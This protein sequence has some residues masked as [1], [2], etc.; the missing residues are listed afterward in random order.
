MRRHLSSL[1]A[2]WLLCQLA[3][4]VAAPIV[5]GTP[6]LSAAAIVEEC[7]CPGSV[8]GQACPMHKHGAGEKP[9]QPPA[10]DCRLQSACDPASAAL[11]S[12]MGALGYLSAASEHAAY[13]D[14][15]RAHCLAGTSTLSSPTVPE[16]PPPRR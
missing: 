14:Q 13:P 8:P 5:L 6:R 16:A 4:F 7:D 11:V 15:T 9:A 1:S 10:G 3:A 2:F 12:L